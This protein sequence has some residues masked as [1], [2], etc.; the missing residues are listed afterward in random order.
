MQ[1]HSRALY[2][3]S[4]GGILGKTSPSAADLRHKVFIRT[5]QTWEAGEWNGSSRKKSPFVKGT[6]PK[7][8]RSVPE[9][10]RYLAWWMAGQKEEKVMRDEARKQ[11]RVQSRSRRDL[12]KLIVKL[13]IILRAIGKHQKGFEN[14]INII[15]FGF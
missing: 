12:F 8:S 7:G 3:G 2:S 5:S 11:G 4:A 6:G 15:T 9:K 14:K 10:E 1:V 13:E